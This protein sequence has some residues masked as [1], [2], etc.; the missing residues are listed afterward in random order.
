VES[1]D[2]DVQGAKNFKFF[3]ILV[4]QHGQVKGGWASVNILRT[5]GRGVNIMR[6]SADIFYEWLLCY[7]KLTT[8]LA[9]NLKKLSF[10]E[11]FK[12]LPILIFFKWLAPKMT[13][14]ESVA[15]KSSNFNFF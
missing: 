4:C 8:L 13:S 2:A 15:T 11:V 7:F 5:S 12:M 10:F 1:L 6:F 14:D 3:K 9:L